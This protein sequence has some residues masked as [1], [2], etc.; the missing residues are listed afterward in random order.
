M[1]HKFIV[2]QTVRFKPVPGQLAITNRGE[3]FKIV[4]L[5]PE[6]GGVY[7]CQLKSDQDGHERIAREDQLVDL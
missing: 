5:L 6:A 3:T 4:R 1:A 7:Q 2:G